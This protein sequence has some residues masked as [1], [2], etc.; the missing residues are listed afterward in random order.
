MM[1]K[2]ILFTT[3]FF[4]LIL[5]VSAISAA[6]SIVNGTSSVDGSSDLV[7]NGTSS[8]DVDGSSDLVVNGTSSVD[9]SSDL[10]VNDTSDK[11]TLDNESLDNESL[12]NESLDNE[13]SDKETEVIENSKNTLYD[14][15]MELE[16]SDNNFTLKKD[17]SYDFDLY[18]DFKAVL[19]NKE[20]FVI[21]GKGHKIDGKGKTSLFYIDAEN[22]TLK[23]L[24]FVN[25]NSING[26]AIEI[27]E[28]AKNFKFINCQFLNNGATNGGAIY[29]YAAGG[30][31]EDC[32]FD[33]N[34][35]EFG[36]AGYFECPVKVV[37][38]RFT[39]N[40][41][42][43][44][45]VMFYG[46][47]IH[48]DEK[49]QLNI[50]TSAR[51]YC[52]DCVGSIEDCIFD[53]NSADTS[54]VGHY[55][56]DMAF[57]NC[58]F[59]NNHAEQVGLFQVIP[60]GAYGVTID[61][62]NMINNSANKCA[63]IHGSCKL[64]LRN[65]NI[66]NNSA[67]MRG[68]IYLSHI[69]SIENCNFIGN[70]VNESGGAISTIYFRLIKECNFE[71]NIAGECCGAIFIPENSGE[72]LFIIGSNFTNNIAGKGNSIYSEN[73]IWTHSNHF[74]DD[75]DRENEIFLTEGCQYFEFEDQYSMD[76]YFFNKFLEENGYV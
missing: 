1:K 59:T 70:H 35:A 66:I 10:V 38:N 43:Y 63:C 11:E 37:K 74:N 41:A 24:I 29:T 56:V 60:G 45:G 46:G 58:N 49:K 5:S 55:F 65:S 36:G 16:E 48:F 21:D 64:N 40:H 44:C 61:D 52:G 30:L 32:V 13:T 50:L 12:D 57:K 42:N 4:M 47:R 20:N 18:S 33:G 34:Q 17:Y 19:I 22:V 54:A 3:I 2:F 39:N 68:V 75:A 53:N 27:S 69:D 28:K 72:K 67:D 71:N 9:G 14:L 25:G 51:D 7:V 6:D 76:M 62:C 15:Q 23:N 26:G 31:L 8:V 73:S